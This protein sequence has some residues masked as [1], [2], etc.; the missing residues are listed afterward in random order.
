MQSLL[1]TAYQGPGGCLSVVLEP[2]SDD[3]CSYLQCAYEVL[4]AKTLSHV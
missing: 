3:A 4:K 2:R 1:Q